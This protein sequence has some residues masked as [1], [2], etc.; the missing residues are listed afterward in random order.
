MF[1]L[2]S[3]NVE[4][5]FMQCLFDEDVDTSNSKP[6]QGITM[7]V[8]FDPI[9]LRKNLDKIE[10]LLS[11]LPDEFYLKTEDRPN[12]GGGYSFLNLCSDKNGNLWTGL[13]TNCDKLLCLGLAIDKAQILLPREF[14][15]MFP[16]GVPYIC[17]K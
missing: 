11:Q 12:A 5:V 9:Q 3:Q 7:K 8:E 10:Q 13:Q 2:T 4:T 15:N 1:E 16:G 14:W 17:I 6:V